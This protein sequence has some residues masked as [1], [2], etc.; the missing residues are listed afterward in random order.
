VVGRRR[1]DDGVAAVGVRSFGPPLLAVA[2]LLVT[3]IAATR[4]GTGTLAGLRLAFRLAYGSGLVAVIGRA[5]A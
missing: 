2:A 3:G 1:R 4:R 5:V